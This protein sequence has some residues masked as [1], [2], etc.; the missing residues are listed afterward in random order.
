M[1]S[2]I[3]AIARYIPYI[4]FG[5]A[6]V[7]GG[8][9]I[10]QTPLSFVSVYPCRVVDTRN[11]AGTFGGPTLQ[12]GTIRTFPIPQ[13]SCN[14]P[15]NAT[16][17]FFNLGVAPQSTHFL[18]TIWPTG[19][20]QPITSN[21]N[22]PLGV[23]VSNGTVVMAGTNGAINV[24][25]SS[26]TDI[27][28]DLEG[29]FI[30]QSSS[31][32]TALGIGASNA[33]AQNTAVGFNTLQLNA[34]SSNTAIGSYALAANSAG[35]NNVALGANALLSNALGSA[36]TAIGTQALL[37]NLVGND[38]TA[39]GF[40]ALNTNTIGSSDVAIGA[41][42]LGNNLTGDFDTAIG[43]GSL[44]ALSGGS[45]NIALGF[46]AGQLITTGSNN[47]D[48]GH[49]GFAT[50]SGVIRI[51]TVNSQTSTYVS[52]VNNS[53]VTGVPVL[54]SSAGQLGVASSSERF[55]DEIA[56]IGSGSDAVMRLRPVSFRYRVPLSDGSKPLHYGLIAEEVAKVYPELVF[57]DL[58]GKP[59]T[60]A[61][62]E[63]PVLLLSEIQKQHGVIDA[64]RD[65]LNS[66][67]KTIDTLERRLAAL[68]VAVSIK[69]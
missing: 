14:V 47:I 1:V 34:G 10:A 28:L 22:D 42:S 62:Q 25:A 57:H 59:F 9:A 35:N 43:T 45:W 29:Y 66:Q 21:L 17:Y 61:Y 8:V 46:Q 2:S 13:G 52:G 15:A 40:G 67:Q 26:T 65:Q 55:K 49:Q 18:V 54:I 41:S 6:V 3:T 38:N 53:T 4:A 44:S 56:N 31:T 58:A 37:N 19:Q 27:I 60:V 64:Q 32:S 30:A 48:I 63:L 7:Q 33:G 51:G 11:P 24:F 23:V 50:D 20:N 12:P 5:Y 36:D 69:R 16:A 68:E 39:I